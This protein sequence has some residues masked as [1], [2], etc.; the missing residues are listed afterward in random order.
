MATIKIKYNLLKYKGA[1]MC[2]IDYH[3][4]YIGKYYGPQV[5]SRQK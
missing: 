5:N 4:N 1:C 3:T 2:L